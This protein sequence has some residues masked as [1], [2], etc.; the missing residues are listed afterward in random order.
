[1]PESVYYLLVWEVVVPGVKSSLP[2]QCSYQNRMEVY[3]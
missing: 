3:L 1:M 2:V